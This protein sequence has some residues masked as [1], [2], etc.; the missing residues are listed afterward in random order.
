MDLITSFTGPDH[1]GNSFSD[2]QQRQLLASGNNDSAEAIGYDASIGISS[3]PRDP[4]ALLRVNDLAF[5][6]FPAP[7]ASLNSYPKPSVFQRVKPKTYALSA[8]V[9]GLSETSF[10]KDDH[11]W[12]TGIGLYLGF[13]ERIGL[14]LGVNYLSR[15]FRIGED[16]I[17][18]FEFPTAEPRYVEDE[19]ES[20]SGSPNLLQFPLGLRV[21]LLTF[22]RLS[23][24]TE[25]GIIAT[26]AFP[27]NMIYT[28]EEDAGD[29][30]YYDVSIENGL[31]HSLEINA[32]YGRL[33]VQYNWPKRWGLQLT[34]TWQQ[35]FGDFAY[36]YGRP[37]FLSYQ[38]SGV[39]RF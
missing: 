22:G 5:P 20:I 8:G 18:R 19:L 1:L 25:G 30:V 27:T 38:L 23:T 7:A 12:Q 4:L 24:F 14:R 34:A 37:D 26:R 15:S 35:G 13:G 31:N 33:G 28:F 11:G 32:W 16:D 6:T 39:L 17:E 3:L 2:Y 9:G 36:V 29:E 10:L 21:N